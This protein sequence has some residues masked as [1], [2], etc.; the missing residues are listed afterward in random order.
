MYTIKKPTVAIKIRFVFVIKKF[1]TLG[2]NDMYLIQFQLSDT[3]KV[4]VAAA[5][6]FVLLILSNIMLHAAVLVLHLTFTLLH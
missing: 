3:E 2:T 6:F 1:V 4:S 5:N